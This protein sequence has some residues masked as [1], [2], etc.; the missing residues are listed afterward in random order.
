MVKR[1]Q[2]PKCQLDFGQEVRFF[3][4]LSEQHSIDDYEAFYVEVCCNGVQQTCSCGC[5]K[6][7]TWAG[8]KKGYTSKYVRGHNASV[9][10]VYL[11]KDR[12]K[13]FVEKRIE[14]YKTGRIKVWNAGLTK[15]SD[16]RV[17]RQS[18]AVSKTLQNLYTSGYAS[19]QTGRTKDNDERVA[20]LV[21]GRCDAFQSGSIAVWNKGKTKNDDQRLALIA[22]KISI[23]NEQHNV[24]RLT[25]LELQ[26]RVQESDVFELVTPPDDYRNKYQLLELRCKAAGHFTKKNLAML[27]HTPVCFECNPKESKGQ[28]ELFEFIK[29]I[30]PNALLSNRKVISPLELDIYVPSA[31]LGIEYDGLYWHSELHRNQNYLS[32]KVRACDKAGVKF[33]SIFSDEWR[34]K[35][36]IVES[37]ILHRLNAVQAR[38]GARECSIEQLDVATRRTFFNDSHL[39]GDVLSTISWGL[40]YKGNVVAAISLRKPFHAKYA[41]MFEVARFATMP[42]VSISGA[43]SR[44]AQHASKWAKADGKSTLLTYVDRRVGSARG[45]IEAGFSIL[46]MTQPRFWW[47]DFVHR[48]DRFSIRA[49]SFIGL[50]QEQAAK[51]ANVVKIWGCS[52]LILTL[53]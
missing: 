36:H 50:T 3:K 6:R 45:Y 41:N 22:E 53:S 51:N 30:A 9:D 52:N 46:K 4:H 32:A 49:N 24:N 19:W 21:Q 28:L 38:I 18:I 8:W 25:N 39:D 34:D 13:E 11:N 44:L 26:N 33:M 48:I 14:G 5:H 43:L 1:I 27:K 15:Y 10:S 47:T 31:K 40:I 35:K 2:C 23:S 42:N 29:Q 12:R 17:Q 20:N 37:M 7:L 16:D